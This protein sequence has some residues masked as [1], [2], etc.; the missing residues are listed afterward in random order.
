MRRRLALLGLA[1]LVLVASCDNPKAMR[2]AREIG[3][4][5]L[6]DTPEGRQLLAEFQ[7]YEKMASVLKSHHDTG[8][9]SEEDVLGVLRAAGVVK[10]AAPSKVPGHKPPPAPP[11]FPVSTYA[12]AYRW[13]L[14]A[15]VV[16]SEFGSRWGKHH[17]GLDVAADMGVPVYAAAPG[18]VI[19]ADDKL[20]GYG[21]VVIVQHDQRTTTLYAH[22]SAFKVRQGQKVAKGEV[23]SL[24][25]STGHSTGP[26]VHFEIRVDGKPAPPRT[27][28]PKSRF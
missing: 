15:G 13:P 18:K 3:D 9:L 16:S 25:G 26:H 2:L 14:R 5:V 19:Y 22:N 1:S 7:R 21:N 24:L 28:L 17:D 20:R 23:I 8:G 4:D 11:A 6:G 12:G 10:A 27:L